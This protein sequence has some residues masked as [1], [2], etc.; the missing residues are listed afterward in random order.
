MIVTTGARGCRL[1]GSSSSV[2]KPTDNALSSKSS[3]NSSSSSSAPPTIFPKPSTTAAQ[4]AGSKLWVIDAITP[5]SVMRSLI[6]ETGFSS[7][8]SAS[9]A[10]VN[11]PS[12]NE[13]VL[14]SSAAAA[15]ASFS[16]VRSRFLKLPRRLDRAAARPF[17]PVPIRSDVRPLLRE[18][19]SSP[20][21]LR[22]RLRFP[23]VFGEA[24]AASLPNTFFGFGFTYAPSELS[25]LAVATG[26][27]PP[28]EGPRSL[29]DC[30]L[31]RL[32]GGGSAAILC[33]LMGF[34]SLSAGCPPRPP[35]VRL[36]LLLL[37]LLL[38][39]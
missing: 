12:G 26:P 35:P 36:F 6:T 39:L 17:L 23:W 34:S 16:A 32:G 18:S 30:C 37:L 20:P 21:L 9:S 19:L 11:G 15:R 33:T 5:K 2:T 10:T 13:T 1:S 14:L 31:S 27:D 29:L 3:S 7:I 4:V 24:G 8:R 25:V 28:D 22:P 38:F